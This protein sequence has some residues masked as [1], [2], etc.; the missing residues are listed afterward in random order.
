MPLFFKYVRDRDLWRWQLPES[1]PI[2]FA[3]WA[4]E[5]DMESIAHFAQALD[6]AKGYCRIVTEGAAMQR[7]AEALVKEQ[8]ARMRW[9][10]IGGYFVP[11]VNAT[12]L[13]SEVG[14]SL[15]RTMPAIAFCAYYMDRSDGKR[16]WG[17]RGHGKVNLSVVAQQYGG[18]GHTDA[19]GF[20][21]EG[22]WLPQEGATP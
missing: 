17:L 12:T 1:K 10:D 2:S 13:L 20:I 21:T 14:D 22:G 3:Y 7:Y 15:C 18:G 5:K 16:Q 19:A 8:A 9:G 4:I 11:I 6:E